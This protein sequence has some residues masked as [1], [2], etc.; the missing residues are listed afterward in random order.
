VAPSG[1]LLDLVEGDEARVFREAELAVEDVDDL[2]NVLAAQA[3][4]RTILLEAGARVD[5]E[6][7]VALCR[8][9]LVDDDDTRG[10][11]RSVEEVRGQS[12]DPLDVALADEVA[13]DVGFG[14]AAEERAVGQDAGAFARALQRPD[15]ME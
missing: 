14:V 12:D 1:V 13:A 15:D 6:D 2:V 11:A 5:H 7:A 10:N 4:L 8:V 3:I 9:V